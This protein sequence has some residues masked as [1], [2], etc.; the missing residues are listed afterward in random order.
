MSNRL[1]SP[2]SEALH[3]EA[4]EAL[5]GGV[6]SNLHKSPH[7][8]YPIYI[9]H[10]KGSRLYD[11]DGNEYIDYQA[12]YGPMI[13]GY[14][15]EAVNRAVIEQVG[16]GSQFAAPF[17]ELNEVSIA[18]RDIIPCAEMVTY[19]MS[20]TEACMLAFRLARA[21]TGKSKIIKFE[22]HYH[23]WSDEGAV[24]LNADSIGMM[25]P[26]NRPWKTLWSFGQLDEYVAQVIVLPWND[27]DLLEETMKRHGHDVA[28]IVTEPVMFNCEPVEPKPGFLDGLREI[29]RRHG[30]LL[31][32]DEIITGFRLA[33]GGAQD[34]FGVTP[35]LSTFGKAVAAGYPLA[36]VAGSKAILESGVHPV[37]TFNAN[38]ILMAACKA[39]LAELRKPGFY[40]GLGQLTARLVDGIRERAQKHGIM[41]Y[42]NAVESVWQIAFGISGPLVDYRDGFRVDREMYHRFRM[43]MLNRGVRV[44][45]TRGRQYV[46]AAHDEQDVEQTLAVVDEVFGELQGPVS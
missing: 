17:R 1:T 12:A 8:A 40:T 21:Y 7:E 45:P 23:G 37:G 30:S 32:F 6:A 35:D 20:G 4:R 34:Y 14:C 26:R 41:A 18:L 31:I 3:R 38:P 10:G 29:T 25:G 42:I 36:G 15:P 19:T 33:L 16:K 9:D 13:L 46:T 11:I 28:A 2:T 5:V 22:G 39:T 24:S 27:L 43:E 44:H